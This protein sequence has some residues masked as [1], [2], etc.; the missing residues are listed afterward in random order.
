MPIPQQRFSS[1]SRRYFPSIFS[2]YDAFFLSPSS[3]A[4]I[5]IHHACRSR[6]RDEQQTRNSCTQRFC[7]LM[8]M[9]LPFFMPLRF[10]IFRRCPIYLFAEALSAHGAAA[11]NMPLPLLFAFFHA[12]AAVVDATRLRRQRRYSAAM[13]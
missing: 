1:F 5:L 8:L 7:A 2:S 13:L 10:F 3:P 12:A 11:D 6:S 4:R 9:L